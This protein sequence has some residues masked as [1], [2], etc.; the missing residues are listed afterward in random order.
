M[1]LWCDGVMVVCYLLR[2]VVCGIVYPPTNQ[3][4]RLTNGEARM[5]RW[6]YGVMV[7]WW[8]L[9]TETSGVWYSAPTNQPTAASHER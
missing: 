9:L 1:V 8:L 6:C 2:L 4:Q 3:L 5:W 7:L